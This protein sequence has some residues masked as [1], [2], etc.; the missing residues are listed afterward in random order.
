MPNKK[1]AATATEALTA[2]G[3]EKRPGWCQKWI[4]QVVQKTHGNKYDKYFD[5]SAYLT[6]LNFKKSPY[7]VPAV[8]PTQVGDILYKGR[9]TS[10][11]HGHVG[12]RIL[13]NKVAEN[14][15]SH[16]DPSA[17]DNDARGTRSLDAYGA[18]ELIVRLPEK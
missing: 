2:K 4:R 16:V 7:A 5:D 8:E 17:G 14:S 6:M 18:Y 13:G 10:G 3:Y 15:S 1:L 9:K 11:K 12:I